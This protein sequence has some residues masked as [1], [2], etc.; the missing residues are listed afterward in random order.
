M[1]LLL[2]CAP[3]V[4]TG[5]KATPIDS[6]TDSVPESDTTPPA[7]TAL[8]WAEYTHVDGGAIDG[9]WLGGHLGTR[10]YEAKTGK[11]ACDVLGDWVD[12]GEA[13]PDCPIC[14]WAF[15]LTV[16]NSTLDGQCDQL[17]VQGA[18]EGRWDGYTQAWGFSREKEYAG[19]IL[20][21]ALLA[22]YNE[23]WLL[24]A[25]S[26]GELSTWYGDGTGFETELYLDYYTVR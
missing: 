13:P 4:D 21:N 26:D 12:N 22:Y 8:G 7:D 1:L 3:I 17:L 2:A 15:T 5:T 16:E 19:D 24:F 25:Y 18:R 6:A 10:F 11:I 20:N 14:D 23:Y 9:V